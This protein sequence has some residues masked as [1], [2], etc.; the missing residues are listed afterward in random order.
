MKVL[1]LDFDG[2]LNSE[3]TRAAFKGYP[4]DFSPEQLAKFD[5][6][7][8]ALI[9]RVCRMAG[10]GIVLSSSWR[11]LFSVEQCVL[12]LGLPII[13]RTPDFW[14][15]AGANRGHEIAMW[16]KANPEVTHYAIVDDLGPDEFLPHQQPHF[17]QTDPD[18]GLSYKDH[19]TLMRILD[20]PI[21]ALEPA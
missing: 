16:L 4:D 21:A 7:A 19:I 9:A 1:F 3:R 11:R 17:V 8:I 14:D 6:V 20:T 18:N 5:P 13:D 10:A 15:E 12:G 2:V